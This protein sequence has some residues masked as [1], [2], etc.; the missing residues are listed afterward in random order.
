LLERGA[1]I[2]LIA[3]IAIALGGTLYDVG[4]QM[5]GQTPAEFMRSISDARASRERA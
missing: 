4:A 1:S 3:K 2:Y 5:R